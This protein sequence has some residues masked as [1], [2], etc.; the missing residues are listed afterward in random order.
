[1]PE[2]LLD[3]LM[4]VMVCGDRIGWRN[5]ARKMVIYASDIQF[6]QAGDGR[7]AGILEPNDCMCHM[8]STG[9]YSKA[10]IQTI[11]QLDK[12]YKKQGRTT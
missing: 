1:M 12:S 4:Q 7:L 5:K 3:G 11:R 10:E 9:K 6:H 8:D 2:G